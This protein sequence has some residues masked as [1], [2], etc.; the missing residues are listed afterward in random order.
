[1]LSHMRLAMRLG[2]PWPENFLREAELRQIAVPVLMIWG[3]ENPYAT[4]RSVDA[5]A[6]SYPRRASR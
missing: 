4:R 3:D 1:M 6:H 5:P 2:R